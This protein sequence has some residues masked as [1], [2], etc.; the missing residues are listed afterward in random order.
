MNEFFI[1][2]VALLVVV[3]I[4]NINRCEENETFSG[5][6]RLCTPLGS[7]EKLNKT[8]QTKKTSYS[9]LHGSTKKGKSAI[10]EPLYCSNGKTYDNACQAILDGQRFSNCM[11]YF[12]PPKYD[13]PWLSIPWYNFDNNFTNPSMDNNI[14]NN[15]DMC[16]ADY[17]PVIC[18]NGG[19]YW[20]SCQAAVWGQDSSKCRSY[21][22]NLEHL[23]EEK[24]V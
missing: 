6:I 16:T 3:L 17:N 18:P 9:S 24:K 21:F 5:N 13:I 8:Q 2:L 19:T 4:I 14:D 7:L 11:L 23:I 12:P 22:P 20:N 1:I 10:Y 15:M